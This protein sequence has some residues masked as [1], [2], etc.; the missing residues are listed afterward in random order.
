MIT[1]IITIII[2]T[3][4]VN[5]IFVI[6]IIIVIIIVIIISMIML[7][8]PRISQVHAR[9]SQTF[10]ERISAMAIEIAMIYALTKLQGST[11][12]TLVSSTFSNIF[13]L[14]CWL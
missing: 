8:H 7:D 2:T 11:P 1:V 3:A 10:R 6:I 4:I 13:F 5:I 12:Q 9:S 14:K